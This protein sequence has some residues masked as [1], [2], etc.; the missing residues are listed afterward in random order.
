MTKDS[1]AKRKTGKRKPEKLSF[2]QD[3][4]PIKNLDH[5]IIETADGRYIKILEVEPTHLG[6]N[7]YKKEV[8]IVLLTD[9]QY[10]VKWLSQ[11]GALPRAQII[12]M[13]QKPPQT[14]EKI[15]RNLKRQMRIADVSGGYYIGLDPM[16]QPDQ[17]IILAIWVL[18]RFIDKV[19]PMA[20]Y[21][22]VYPSQL[23]FLKENVGYE[24]V[25]LYDGEQ[26]LLK[27]LQPQ[28]DM[29]YIVVVPRINM[30]STVRLPNAPCLF[31]TVDFC[32]QDEPE[33]RFYS[34]E[35]TEHED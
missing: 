30:V 23:F 24:I 4:I 13:L 22:A 20:H 28:E 3:F 19:E 1:S 27:L 8:V 14:A 17:R 18:L 6:T 21:P 9:E 7:E 25:V 35:A 2:T 15:L 16:C 34:E 29:K 11:Y 31:A 33:V 32:G 12:K 26:N 10:V 5:G